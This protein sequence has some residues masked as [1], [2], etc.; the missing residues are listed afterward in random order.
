MLHLGDV[1][2]GSFLVWAAACTEQTLVFGVDLFDSFV[3]DGG[4][5][6]F[7]LLRFYGDHVE[8]TLVS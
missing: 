1:F 8:L 7:E 6:L 5:V 4:D 3:L 2:F